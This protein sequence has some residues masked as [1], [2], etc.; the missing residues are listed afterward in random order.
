[1]QKTSRV[2]LNVAKAIEPKTR[3]GDCAGLEAEDDGGNAGAKG[4]GGGDGEDEA[5]HEDHHVQAP[6]SRP[7]LPKLS[8]HFK[9]PL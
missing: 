4:G 1:M 3:R 5:G 2:H 8:L 7:Q 6:R 9:C